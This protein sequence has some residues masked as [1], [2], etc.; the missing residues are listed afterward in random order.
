MSKTTE[1]LA[2]TPAL[3]DP[4]GF[5]PNAVMPHGLTN[6]HV[7]SAMQEFLDFIGFVNTQLLS[8]NIQRLE[9][10]LMAANF[11]SMVG[12]FMTANMPKYCQTIT[13]N[14]YHNGH[15]DIIPKGRHPGEA[16]QYGHEGIEVKASRYDRGWQG[17]NPE[18]VFL[19][20]FVFEANGPRDD[21]QAIVA[22]P[23]RFKMVVG[24]ELTHSDWKF[25]G[26]SAESRRTITASVTTSGYKKMISNWIYL[27]QD[28][29]SQVLGDPGSRR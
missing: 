28:V 4:H 27:A 25:A 17:H 5:N 23:F 14:R 10:M 1:E 15:P 22:K 26:R 16:I 29:R 13:K 6:E 9:S 19:M 3:L 12:E 18:E 20:V 11:S 8:K 21:F 7:R 2:C 24:A